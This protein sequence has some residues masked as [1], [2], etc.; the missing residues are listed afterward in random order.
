MP[1]QISKPPIAAEK[2]VHSMLGRLVAADDAALVPALQS[3]SLSSL[4]ISTPHRVAVLELDRIL[5]GDSLRSA[6]QKKGW[7]F[8]VHNGANVI[9]TINTSVGRKGKHQF[10]H[11]TEGPFVAGTEQAIRR[12]E[13]LEAVQNGRFELL[14]LQAPAIHVVALWLRNLDNDAD[15]IVPIRPAPKPLQANRVLSTSKFMTA[16]AKLAAQ[17][18]RDHA[19]ARRRRTS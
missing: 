1:L 5:N 14:L 12:A 6:A 15:L 18:Q 2:A 8:L 4:A 10:G 16:V 3:A 7:R 9:A 17:V 11:I 19:Q 13:A